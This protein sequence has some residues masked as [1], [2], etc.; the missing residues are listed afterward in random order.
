M[1]TKKAQTKQIFVLKVD[2]ATI[3]I[4]CMYYLKTDYI[5]VVTFRIPEQIKHTKKIPTFEIN[6]KTSICAMLKQ[7]SKNMQHDNQRLTTEKIFDI[8][9]GITNDT[10]E[11]KV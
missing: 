1:A 10:I 2:R 6:K 7:H 3:N 11:N 5:G 9:D 4:K 8:I